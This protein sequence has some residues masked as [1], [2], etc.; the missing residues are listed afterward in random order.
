MDCLIFLGLKVTFLSRIIIMSF[1]VPYIIKGFGSVTFL[2]RIINYQF[3][4]S[5]YR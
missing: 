2:S 3:Y 4:S 1:I 5:L